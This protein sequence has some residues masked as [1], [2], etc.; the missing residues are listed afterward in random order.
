MP[1]DERGSGNPVNPRGPFL[2]VGACG[3]LGSE[4]YLQL[5]AKLAD[6]RRHGVP[7][8][9]GL[10]RS[11]SPEDVNPRLTGGLSCPVELLQSRGPVVTLQE[12]EEWLQ[13]RC[14]GY[15]AGIFHVAGMAVPSQS[16]ADVALMKQANVDLSNVIFSFAAKHNIR[17]VYS[18]CSGV[19][20]CQFLEDGLSRAAHD[21]SKLCEASIAP[22]PFL[23]QKAQIEE[24]W[25]QEALKGRA[26]IVFLRPSTLFGPG[27][28]RL[29]STTVLYDIMRGAVHTKRSGGVSFVDVRDCAKAFISVMLNDSIEAG[30]VMNLTAC[31]MPFADFAALVETTLR[32]R[33]PRIG[34]PPSVEL[35]AAEVGSRVRRALRMPEH[36]SQTPCAVMLRQRFWNVTCQRAKE[37]VDWDPTE[38]EETI[39]DTARYIH[40][41][42]MACPLDDARH[43]AVA[44]AARDGR[45]ELWRLPAGGGG[46]RRLDGYV[47]VL[48]ALLLFLV[49]LI[50]RDHQTIVSA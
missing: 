45:R 49:G 16:P 39:L 44:A 24:R 21:D 28:E 1:Y 43:C 20:G 30:T 15:I 40:A 33:G 13:V 18:S 25:Q 17:C 32:V 37:L 29:S 48:V 14:A 12:L 34:L 9:L 19:V 46:G 4:I 26:P 50:W 10:V 3:F 35:A 47:L 7:R 38:L 6:R 22:F 42:F 11:A 2:I 36:L 8:I 31:N 27:D 5:R 41:T 23:V